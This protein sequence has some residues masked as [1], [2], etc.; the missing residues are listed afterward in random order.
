[1]HLTAFLAEEWLRG[2]DIT[3]AIDHPI[4]ACP[5]CCRRYQNAI[6]TRLGERYVREHPSCSSD[7]FDHVSLNLAVLSVIFSGLDPCAILR[8]FEAHCRR[9]GWPSERA[10]RLARSLLGS[11]F[12]SMNRHAL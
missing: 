12:M 9:R 7:E 1:M 3:N 11:D 4:I 6:E 10:I 2:R 8:F 5:R